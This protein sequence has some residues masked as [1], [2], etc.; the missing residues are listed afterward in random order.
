MNPFANYHKIPIFS[1]TNKA[2]YCVSISRVIA[3]ELHIQWK[4]LSSSLQAASPTKAEREATKEHAQLNSKVDQM[5]L[6]VWIN[7]ASQKE[8][9]L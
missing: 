7:P 9:L 4:W 8:H 1:W 3:N 2:T 6:G 5:I